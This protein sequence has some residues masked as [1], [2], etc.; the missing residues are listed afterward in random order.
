M[1]DDQ[2]PSR[3]QV[4]SSVA[5]VTGAVALGSGAEAANQDAADDGEEEEEAGARVNRQ[6]VGPAVQPFE[7]NYVGQ[8]LIASYPSESEVSPAVVDDCDWPNWQA[9]QTRLYQGM[10]LDRLSRRPQYVRVEFYMNANRPSVKAGAPFIITETASCPDDYLGMEV[11]SVPG[12][13][14]QGEPPGPTVPPS[15]LRSD[16]RSSGG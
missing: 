1:T 15:E 11:Q 7:G 13:V 6:I 4:L 14:T 16:D 9:D 2:R 12:D 8:F 5:G 3:R 10:Y